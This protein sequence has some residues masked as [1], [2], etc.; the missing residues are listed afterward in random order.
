MT[1]TRVE[2]IYNGFDPEDYHQLK[3]TKRKENDIFTIVYT[4]SIYRG[5][6]DP[7]PL[8]EAVSNLKQKGIITPDKLQIQF[9]GSNADVGDIAE[10]YGISEYYFFLGFLPRSAALQLQHDADAVLFLEYNNPAVRGILTG[11]IF[12]YLFFS[13]EIIAV[14][15]DGTTSAGN[16]INE[17]S[18]GICFG[19]DI[20]KIETYLITRVIDKIENKKVKNYDLINIYSRENQAMKMLEY[21]S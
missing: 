5:F 7:S 14:G 11:K 21:I 10:K 2:T 19:T 6:Q 15:I 9:A 20:K 12:E 3:A 16:L 17:T 1:K 18:T 8:F 13:K 4:G